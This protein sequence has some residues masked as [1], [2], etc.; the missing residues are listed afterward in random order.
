MA[1]LKLNEG[2]FDRFGGRFGAIVDP[3]HFLGRS[4]FDIP[5]SRSFPPTNIK[6]NQEAYQIEL[7]VPGFTKDELEVTVEKGML[8]IKGEKEE[9][10][11]S[12]DT[13][14]LV[15]EFGMESFERKFLLHHEHRDNRLEAFLENGILRLVFYE[16]HDPVISEYKRIP[17]TEHS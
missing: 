1:K 17:V 3:T 14:F 16:K 7:L 8:I 12:S 10:L 2:P 13:S 4:A 5:Y 11:P 15:E 6:R 9:T